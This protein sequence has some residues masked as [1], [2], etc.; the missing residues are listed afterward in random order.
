MFR[1]WLETIPY[2]DVD[3]KV[4]SLLVRHRLGVF[5]A[6]RPGDLFTARGP[7]QNMLEAGVEVTLW[8]M[9][10]DREGRWGNHQNLDRF[11]DF[12]DRTLEVFSPRRIVLDLEPSFSAMQAALRGRPSVPLQRAPSSPLHQWTRRKR[13]HGI[14]VSAV[15]PPF[16]QH[17]VWGPPLSRLLGIPHPGDLFNEVHVMLYTSLLEGFS[18]GVIRRED[19]LYVLQEGAKGA[20]GVAL[21]AVGV[22]ALGCE[23]LYRDVRELAEDVAVARAANVASISLFDLGGILQRPDPEGWFR[24][25]LRQEAPRSVTVPHSLRMR[26]AGAL[27][28]LLM[29][30]LRENPRRA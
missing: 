1:V 21:G 28:R 20:Q 6:I 25:L 4:V 30:A 27:G 16:V 15:V 13:E 5:A 29:K 8:P 19:A 12:A 11:L 3:E 7:I 10:E 14:H 9:L 26:A 24:V 2:T 22:G 23:P 17:P 18:R